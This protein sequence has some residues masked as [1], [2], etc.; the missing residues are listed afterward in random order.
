MLKGILHCSVTLTSGALLGFILFNSTP[1]A[2][3]P[4]AIRCIV[5]GI[6]SSV[7]VNNTLLW[8]SPEKKPDDGPHP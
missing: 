7:S 4:E 2:R 5:K 8:A 6:R 3:C 1:L